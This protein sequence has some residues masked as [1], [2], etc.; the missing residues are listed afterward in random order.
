MALLNY[1]TTVD[2][3]KTIG[4]IQRILSSKGACAVSVAYEKGDPSAVHFHFPINSQ[5][6]EF[7]L[8]CKF[9]GVRKVMLA[10]IK[11][12][13]LR[14]HREKDPKFDMQVRRIAWRIIKDWVAA[15]L[16]LIQA[17]QAEVSEVF[18]PYLVS[19]SGDT[20]FETFKAR[21][22]SLLLMLNTP[23]QAAPPAPPV[24]SYQHDSTTAH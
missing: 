11:T 5:V 9:E 4:E 24:H 6:V 13:S 14:R 7:K 1:T 8:P 20:L 3:A 23:R 12:A 2:T 16:A 10:D 15:Q 22:E 17:G 19:N 18:L 21:P